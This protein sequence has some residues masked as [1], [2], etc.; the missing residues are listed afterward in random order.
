MLKLIRYFIGKCLS[1]P[2]T[3]FQVSVRNGT[4]PEK[5]V[6]AFQLPSCFVLYVRTHCIYTELQ[7]GAHKIVFRKDLLA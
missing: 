6:Y 2:E 5:C 1:I 7:V 4:N 3:E